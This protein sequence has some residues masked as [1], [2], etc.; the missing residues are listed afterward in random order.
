M[1]TVVMDG[2]GPVL[3]IDKKVTFTKE[4]TV[5]Q[6]KGNQSGDQYFSLD[7]ASELN[8]FFLFY[9]KSST[10]KLLYSYNSMSVSTRHTIIH[11]IS[12]TRHAG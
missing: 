6:P 1:G 12:L 4:K 9:A 2:E 5:N 11:V 7:E 8:F 10:Y 3:L